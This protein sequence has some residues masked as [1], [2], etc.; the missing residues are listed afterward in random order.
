M[1]ELVVLLI[2]WINANT[3]Y[4]VEVPPATII[5]EKQEV[6]Q[7][8]VGNLYDGNRLLGVYTPANATIALDEG[9]DLDTNEGKATLLHELVHH[10]QA[11][12]WKYHPNQCLYEA[13]AYSIEDKWRREHGM[14]PT[15][16]TPGFIYWMGRCIMRAEYVP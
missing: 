14:K 5:V 10:Y 9:V 7:K 3:A 16:D 1:K 15:V 8:K 2:V 13:E 6:L 4:T 12:T 11:R